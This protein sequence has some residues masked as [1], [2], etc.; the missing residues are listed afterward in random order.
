VAAPALSASEGLRARARAVMPGG[1]SSPVRAFRAV[2]G[3]PPFIV[4]GEG[5]HVRDAD[6]RRFIDLVCSWGPLIAGHA[7]PRVVASIARQA[8][9]G[10]SYGMPSP[11][12]AELAELIV[13][14][15]PRIDMIRFVSSGTEAAMSAIRLARAATGRDAI[16]KFAGGY[17]G[18][19]DALLAKAGS[20]LATFGLPDS[21][22]VPAAAARDTLT[23]AYND[24]D[25]ARRAASERDLAAIIVEPVAGNMG[26]VPPSPGFLDGLRALTREKGALLIFDEVI[27][28]FRIARGGAQER[29]GVAADITCLGKIIGGGL[30]VGAYGASRELMRLVA[31]EGPVYQAGTL[32][33]NPLAMA[34][35][36]ATLAL[37]DGAAYARLEALGARLEAGLARASAE[38]E[39]HARVQ[40]VGSLLTLFFTE[41][42]VRNEEEA[43]A[44]DRAAFARF[45]QAMFRRGVL[46]PPSALECVF[47]SLAHDEATIDEVA[48]AAAEALAESAA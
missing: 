27:T 24:L 21:A 37:L 33:G 1:V 17:H 31:P 16:L 38:A 40:R 11:L 15:F 36:I 18:H 30:P 25:G 28:G 14:A 12:E 34:A 44:T 20:G 23:V 46:L 8:E 43:L 5:A 13:A 45:H 19:A 6:G 7:H 29:Y 42:E 10:T 47:L 9:R 48:D 22:G 41:R 2:G 39:V 4:R 32:S 35:G 26:A 3:E